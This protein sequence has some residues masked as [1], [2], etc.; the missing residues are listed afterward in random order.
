MD[1]VNGCDQC[2]VYYS[3]EYCRL[4]HLNGKTTPRYYEV[5]M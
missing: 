3:S 4:E 2:G 1:D 5:K